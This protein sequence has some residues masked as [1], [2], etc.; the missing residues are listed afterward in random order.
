MTMTLTN[1]GAAAV[2]RDPVRTASAPPAD[3]SEAAK[4]FESMALDEFLQPMFASAGSSDAMFGGGEAE[5]TLKPML[6]TEFAKLMEQRGGL[7][8]AGAIQAKM[9]EMQRDKDRRP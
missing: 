7:G 3:T 5:N 9:E 2:S 6:V 8:L 4:N 1:I